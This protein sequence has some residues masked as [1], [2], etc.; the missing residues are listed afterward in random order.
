[1]SALSGWV[2]VTKTASAPTAG[3]ET[4]ERAG[5]QTDWKV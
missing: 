1:M 3:R 4:R 2:R 5:P